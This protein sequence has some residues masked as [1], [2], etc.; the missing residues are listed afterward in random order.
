M[1][2]TLS[3]KRSPFPENRWV[4]YLRVFGWVIKAFPVKEDK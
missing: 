2:L 1:K 4:L 3:V